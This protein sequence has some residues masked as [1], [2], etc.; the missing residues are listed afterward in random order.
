ML[1]ELDVRLGTR[2]ASVERH[3]ER[4]RLVAESGAGLGEY[5]AVVLTA[6]A[7]QTEALLKWSAPELAAR[8]SH[9]QLAPQWVM[10]LSL[11]EPSGLEEGLEVKIGPL[12][13]VICEARKPGRSVGERWVIHA[14]HE[15]SRKH[16]EEAPETVGRAL[17]DAFWA[18]TGARPQP[19]RLAQPRLWRSARVVTPVGIPCLFDPALRVAAA[20]DWCLGNSVEA[21]FLSGCAAA[22]R[23]NGLRGVPASEPEAPTSSASQL[24]LL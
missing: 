3:A 2:V 20:G 23:L 10:A 8:V 17:L 21:A 16:L 1:H 12:A 15:W 19:P 24:R 7:P 22:G 9:A 18:T 4:W 5:D 11:A 14:S 6:P 13:K